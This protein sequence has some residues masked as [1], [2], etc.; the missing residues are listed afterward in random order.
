MCMKIYCSKCKKPTF[1]G[2]GL[3]IE[4]VLSGIKVEDRC[5]CKVKTSINTNEIKL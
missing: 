5:Q 2:C 1:N 4:K 3:H